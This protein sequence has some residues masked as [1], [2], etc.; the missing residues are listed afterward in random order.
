MTPLQFWTNFKNTKNLNSFLI[1]NLH[2]IVGLHQL[3]MKKV[4]LVCVKY[5]TSIFFW[6]NLKKWPKLGATLGN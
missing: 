5:K 1:N 4:N 3:L 2:L 6:K